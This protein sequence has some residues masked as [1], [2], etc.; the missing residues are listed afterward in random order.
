MT[1]LRRWFE[2]QARRE[3][4]AVFLEEAL[5]GNRFWPYAFYRLRFFFVRYAVA[6]VTHAVTVLLLYK[7]FDRTHFMIV[8]VAYAVASVISNFWW[9]ALE[10]MRREV[11]RLYRL[12]APHLMPKAIGRWLSLAVQLAFAT[13][14]ATA[15]WTVVDVL[16]EGGLK[17][18]SLYVVAIGLRL[19]T[20]FVTR[21]YHGGIYA[22]RRIYRPLPAIIGVE[23]LG[24][25]VTLPLVPLLGAWAL[26]I[27]AL[28]GVPIV[29]GLSFLYTHRAYQF[30]G[31][32]PARSVHAWRLRPPPRRS[33]RDFFGGGVSYALVGMDALLVLVL[34][35]TERGAG[36]KT[37][38]FAL[39][40]LLSPTV[41]AGSEWAQL[42]Y[43]DLK[44]LEIRF[45]RNLK[46]RFE[47]DVLR[48]AVAMGIVFA[49]VATVVGVL[50]S[51]TPVA[52]LVWAVVP[53][54]VALS[55]L[56][57][58]QIRTYSERAYP[59]LIRNGSLCLAGF[60]AVGIFAPGERETVLGLAAVAFAAFLL[61]HLRIER[62]EGEESHSLVWPTEWLSELRSVVGPVRVAAARFYAEPT[63]GR[64]E[65]VDDSWRR[66]QVAER[67]ASSLRRPGKAT[68][69][70]PGLLVWYEPD[71][72]GRM[73]DRSSLATGAGGLLYLVGERSA[74]SGPAALHTAAA[75]QLLGRE[76]ARAAERPAP[77]HGSA[78][79][80][81]T[82]GRMF[83]TG[84]VYAP[85]EP[86][87]VQLDALSV[88]DKRAAVAEA[89]TYARELRPRRSRSR[90]HVTALCEE[91]ELRLIFLV[92]RRAPQRLRDRWESIISRS[93]LQ[94]ALIVA[95]AGGT[96][97]WQPD[98]L[99]GEGAGMAEIRTHLAAS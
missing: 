68:L 24:L 2:A 63:A 71:D 60:A 4:R 35:T 12:R 86:I 54:F 3:E 28:I 83:R 78:E 48:L 49:G 56:A 84:I 26:P 40:F 75:A 51:R 73:H 88:E 20:Q 82:F 81:A 66:R 29:A 90:L 37:G 41:R 44:R 53:F 7:F 11:R 45:F 98:A 58:A 27:G 22:I 57:S 31:I 67:I 16:V 79:L 1:E 50:V 21:A 69:M 14:L 34:F 70:E 30:L 15:V 25:V 61:L 72:G 55:L 36:G 42:L 95:D 89:L 99:E 10:A 97:G 64:R 80:R 19:S 96:A 92:S 17:P 39:L 38:L 62:L 47:R 9:G 6:S 87:P 43:F 74:G 18:A 13:A 65:E 59:A 85:E 94:A 46:R 91:G 5:L 52:N 8:L 32:S 93:N 23:V 33:Y 76:L 77:R